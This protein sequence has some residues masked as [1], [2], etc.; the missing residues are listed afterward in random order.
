MHGQVL[1]LEASAALRERWLLSFSAVH[2]MHLLLCINYRDMHHVDTCKRHNL[3]P[4]ETCMLYALLFC[5]INTMLV[6]QISDSAS[7][8]KPGA[9]TD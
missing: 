2:K 5:S 3:V 6:P 1:M 4:M 8:Q 9:R 7:Q